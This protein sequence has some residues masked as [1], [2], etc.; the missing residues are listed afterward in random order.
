MKHRTETKEK[1]EEESSDNETKRGENISRRHHCPRR[2][3]PD[4]MPLPPST[5]THSYLR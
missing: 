2:H 3:E 1:E 4:V 5:N